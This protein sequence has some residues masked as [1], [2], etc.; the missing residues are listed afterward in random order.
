LENYLIPHLKIDRLLLRPISCSE[1]GNQTSFSRR[2]FEVKGKGLATDEDARNL[3]C[4]NIFVTPVK[5]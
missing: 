5:Y 4:Y 1:C 3:A 2:V